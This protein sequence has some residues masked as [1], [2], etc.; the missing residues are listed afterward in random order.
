MLAA[1]SFAYLHTVKQRGLITV[2]DLVT[3]PKMNREMS[4]VEVDL[5]E[6]QKLAQLISLC[7]LRTREQLR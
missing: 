6:R 7:N 2:F 5:P 4:K 3:V 1:P